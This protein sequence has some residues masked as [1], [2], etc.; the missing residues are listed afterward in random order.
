MLRH[1]WTSSLETGFIR[2]G[3]RLSRK[4]VNGISGSGCGLGRRYIMT[5]YW[6]D[7]A[8][9][10]ETVCSS[11]RY[12]TKEWF[13]VKQWPIA[14]QFICFCTTYRCNPRQSPTWSG[15]SG[16]RQTPDLKQPKISPSC[17]TKKSQAI[18]KPL[19]TSQE[20]QRAAGKG[21]LSSQFNQLG[22]ET[23]FLIC[24][25]IMCPAA[26][27]CPTK[28]ILHVWLYAQMDAKS[29]KSTSISRV[30]PLLSEPVPKSL[31]D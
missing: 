2:C 27:F 1:H 15:Q 6:E 10:L 11:W 18:H 13:I 29:K 22:T 4:A 5:E 16:S 24:F 14:I 3:L 23:M 8:A 9:I 17:A 26:K 28:K 31:F 25:V 21:M 12:D 19:E 20:M 7:H 30:K